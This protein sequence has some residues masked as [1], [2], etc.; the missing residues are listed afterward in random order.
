MGSNDQFWNRDELY[1]E[2]W[3]TPMWTLAKKYGTS[4]V[5]L[6][7]VCRKLTI[8]L[9]GRGY[10]AREQAGQEVARSPLPPAKD[11][12]RLHKPAPP[13]E[14][15][16]VDELCTDDERAQLARL[17]ASSDGVLLRSISSHSLIQQARG[18]LAKASA[19][20]RGIL[21]TRE[22]CLDIR[23]S[24]TSLDRAMRI[25]ASLIATVEAEGFT[26]SVG[27][28]HREHTIAKIYGQEIKFGLIERVDRISQ[29]AAPTG[30]L[31][32]RVLTFRRC[33]AWT[34]RPLVPGALP[35]P[36]AQSAPFRRKR[37]PDSAPHRPRRK[38]WQR[39]FAMNR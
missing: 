34:G 20:D 11:I 2:V 23:V 24:K 33:R 36:S 31:V 25:L 19:D 18:I 38:H 22:Q 16:A 27:N 10:W 26:V 9:P 3:S 5:G 12:V 15:P 1:E 32:D 13:K 30:S 14:E 28:G 4:D 29:V 35:R 21:W 17:D 37:T 39:W 8:P 6:A 7:K